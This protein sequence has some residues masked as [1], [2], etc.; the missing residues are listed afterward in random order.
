MADTAV[1]ATNL[2][3][4]STGR[5]PMAEPLW[6]HWRSRTDGPEIFAAASLQHLFS[7]ARCARRASRV[8]LLRRVVLRLRWI[9]DHERGRLDPMQRLEICKYEIELSMRSYRGE[10]GDR[11]A[12]MQTWH[13]SRE[14]LQ[15]ILFPNDEEPARRT[16][17]AQIAETVRRL[18]CGT[19]EKVKDAHE[20]GHEIDPAVIDSLV[21]EAFERL[22]EVVPLEVIG[23]E[24]LT[25]LTRLTILQSNVA[26]RRRA[27]AIS[28]VEPKD[29]LALHQAAIASH[30]QA[31]AL[32]W[33]IRRLA[34]R[35]T[36]ENPLLIRSRLG[37]DN[38]QEYI[39]CVVN[40]RSLLDPLHGRAHALIA[41]LDAS[42]RQTLDTFTR[43]QGVDKG[44]HILIQILEATV[45][46]NI[47]AADAGAGDAGSHPRR[48]DDASLAAA[49]ALLSMVEPCRT[50]D[51]V[52]QCPAGASRHLVH[53]PHQLRSRRD[54]L[55]LERRDEAASRCKRQRRRVFNLT[56]VWACCPAKLQAGCAAVPAIK[57]SMLPV[58]SS[59]VPT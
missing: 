14:A 19:L 17:A 35:R 41:R 28:A 1:D 7:L 42:M 36:R 52:V 48:W 20:A 23:H 31:V 46:R 10:P 11:F 33:L 57:D 39:T 54:R 40:L 43:E 34:S 51:A 49:R 24:V 59:A 4:E 3:D 15:A 45:A 56:D 27:R 5:Q 53:R 22:A 44:H 8:E 38:A 29:A 37:A 18:R 32:Y 16:K 13:R 21:L 6:R 47:F 9:D 30:L 55:D 12:A 25:L 26:R 50:G 58:W 2:A